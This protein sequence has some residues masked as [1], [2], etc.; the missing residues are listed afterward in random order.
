MDLIRNFKLH[1]LA[2]LVVAISDMIGTQKFGLVVLL[3][4]LYAMV[5]GGIIS[6]PKLNILKNVLPNSC[7]SPCSSWW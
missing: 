5:L 4:L 6:L 1:A 3:P 7:R 2:L